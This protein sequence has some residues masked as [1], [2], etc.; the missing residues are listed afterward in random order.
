MP[1]RRHSTL[2]CTRSSAGSAHLDVHGLVFLDTNTTSVCTA[3]AGLVA[4]GSG[5]VIALPLD[6]PEEERVFDVKVA[7]TIKHA[8][9]VA[10]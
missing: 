5:R 2:S 1:H 6:D 3:T 4:P 10:R 8:G 9:L 7:F